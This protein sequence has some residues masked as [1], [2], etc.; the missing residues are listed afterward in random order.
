LPEEV[1][2]SIA[3]LRRT[4]TATFVEAYANHTQATPSFH[5]IRLI[6]AGI[7]VPHDPESPAPYV[8]ERAGI[9]MS[10][11][12]A[13]ALRDLLTRM[14]D[15]YEATTGPIRQRPR[16]EEGESAQTTEK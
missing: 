13:K 11:E 16:D 14:I 8:E 3:K 1:T 7:I 10:W 4:R 2:Y 12:H 5:D 9:T 6:F 15:G